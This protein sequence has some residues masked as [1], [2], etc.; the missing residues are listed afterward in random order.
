MSVSPLDPNLIRATASSGL[1]T[2]LLDAIDTLILK[3]NE[4]TQ[5]VIPP[6][7]GDAGQRFTYTAVG[8]EGS[9][10]TITLP[11]ARSSSAYVAIVQGGGAGTLKLYDVVLSTRTTTTFQVRSSAPMAAGDMLQI[12]ADDET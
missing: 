8:N 6:P 4:L 3:V 2:D 12:Y 10:F 1:A 11:A 9:L 5:V 7:G